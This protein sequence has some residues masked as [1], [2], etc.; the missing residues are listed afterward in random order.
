M[1]QRVDLGG[2]WRLQIASDPGTAVPRSFG[3]KDGWLEAQ[4]P[5]TVH[6]DLLANNKI[7]DPFARLNEVEVQW[8]ADVDWRYRR[9]VQVPA[10]ILNA[11][12]VELVAE[13]LDTFAGVWLNG[14]SV[15]RT[16]N[17]FTP[18]RWDVKSLLRPGENELTIEFESPV[19]RT[20]E[21]LRRYG[22][23]LTASHA[24]ERIYARKAQYSFGWDWGPRLV[25][26]GIWRPIYLESWSVARIEHVHVRA[27]R[28]SEEEAV[29]RVGVVLANPEQQTVEVS[30][31]IQGEEFSY[32]DRQATAA[33]GVEFEV[34]VPH[35]ALWW[36]NGLGSQPLYTARLVLRSQD[37]VL[38]SQEVRFGI[39]SVEL[40]L[41]DGGEDRFCFRING[42][43]LFCKGADWIP[44]DTFIPRIE[45]RVYRR[46][47]TM[48]RDAHM[49]MLRVWGGGIYEQDIFYDLCDELGIL[50]WQDFMFACSDYPNQEWF[51]QEVRREVEANVVR[52]RNHPSLALWCGNNE[53]EWVFRMHT[54]RPVVEMPGFELFHDVI[55][56]MLSQLDPSRPYWPSSPWGKEEDPCSP[57]S[58][59][60]HN[61]EVWS[62]WQDY[63]AYRKDPARFVTEFGFQA[64][65]NVET[66][67]TV[68]G[69]ADRHPQSPAMEHHQKQADGMPRLFRFLAA[70]YRVSTR[71]EDFIYRCQ[72]VQAEAIQAGVEHWR[73]RKFASAGTL[74]W[75]LNDCWPVASWSAIDSAL[76]PKA[77]YYYAKRFFAPVHVAVLPANDVL[78][79]WGLN[80]T[81][82][83]VRG[84]L[85]AELRSVDWHLIFEI[86]VAAE[87]EPN[88]AVRL[89]EVPVPLMPERELAHL[90][91][92]LL[93]AG[94]HGCPENVFWLR[95]PKHLNFPNPKI[96][97][98]ITK[99]DG[100]RV[101]QLRADRFVKG[102]LLSGPPQTFFHDNFVDLIPER[103]RKVVFESEL[104]DEEVGHLLELTY[105]R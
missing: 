73:R 13:G 26:S 70:H 63:D 44:A 31:A 72:L 67:E 37:I 82:E 43:P 77:L 99:V 74:F 30:V 9:S 1:R 81:R 69:P 104:S 7:P 50:V 25:T 65:A 33:N 83:R 53:C 75:Q 89:A 6:T 22:T 17:M 10:E 36:P 103:T 85:Q 52:L 90:L 62:G 55:P 48:A 80:D 56:Q 66:Y 61:W 40:L 59:N 78:E 2:T 46:L 12:H 79:V 20:T 42:V 15:A 88:S 45:E 92:V 8:V 3:P 23:P 16:A 27:L 68:L 35:P 58:G 86:E 97:Y 105:Y 47:L 102:L 41:N 11:S 87:L 28:V 39:R 94:A 4:I 76:R 60:R 101:V 54:G 21:L 34:R 93:D 84:S 29:L 32:R 57:R 24:P 49:N 5:G 96:E 51:K 19:R 38:D 100:Q 64:P 95:R 18:Y 71:F 98:T 91:W 14:R